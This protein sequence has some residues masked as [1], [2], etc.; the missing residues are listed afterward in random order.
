M[1]LQSR[2]IT[3]G[4]DK[5]VN[6]GGKNYVSGQVI[7]IKDEAGVLAPIF[8]DIDGLDPIAQNTISNVTNAKGQFTFFIEE[9][10]YTAE[11]N[12]QSIP[13]FVFG[14]DYFNNQIDFVTNQIL[15]NTQ[16]YSAGNFT[17]GFTFTELNQYGN[18]TVNDGG[19]DYATTFWYIG[20]TL[21]HTVAPLT[22]PRD[23]P[24]LYQ[25]R[26]FNS[27]E[28]IAT[29]TTENTQ[30]FIDSF[31]LK[32][33]QS[34]TDGLTKINTRTLLGGEVYEVRK[35]SDDSFATIYSD[36]DGDNEIVQNGISNVSGSDGV[37]IFYVADGS[38]YI[39]SGLFESNFGVGVNAESVS[40]FT[41]DLSKQ[42]ALV[43]TQETITINCPSDFANWQ[44]AID[45]A[46]GSLATFTNRIIVHLEAGYEI[47]NGLRLTGGD[48]SCIK[49]TSD[50]AIV[51]LSASFVGADTSGIPAGILGETPRQPL[52]CAYNANCPEWDVV[53]DMGNNY[54]T[55]HQLAEASIVVNP[56]KG[57]VNA[58]FRGIQVHGKANLYSA[59]YSGASGT[60]LR[61]QQASRVNA[62]DFNG[63]NS[64]KTD[65]LTNSAIYAS[66]SSILEFRGG[67]AINSGASGLIAR[68]SIVT[69][70]EA[71]FDGAVGFGVFSESQGANASFSNGSALNTGS[72]SVATGSAGEVACG[73]ADLSRPSSPANTLNINGGTIFVNAGTTVNGITGEAAIRGASNAPY[74][75]A[76]CFRGEIKY[77]DGAGAFDAGNYLT[78][79][80]YERKS[81]NIQ[82]TY[83]GA[84]TLNTGTVTPDSFSGN[85]TL[86][87]TESFTSIKSVKIEAVGRTSINGGGSRV[88]V[89]VFHDLVGSGN[90]FKIKN[91]SMQLD[92]SNTTLNVES[93]Q[94][95]IDIVGTWR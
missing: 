87:A 57:V 67:S 33:F 7:Y 31:A 36:K 40:K 18:A 3:A 95:Y 50:D 8:R 2:T 79:G 74:L 90:N 72:A 20:G 60:S 22:N 80:I 44:D 61:L 69:A 56:L 11:Y 48:Y 45:F 32:I 24:L 15:S 1:A 58:G 23:F 91:E 10:N 14:A 55:G 81:N 78:D 64:C 66:R 94:L 92:G 52:L 59:N 75:N 21:P 63:D 13:L 70:D 93:V 65:D 84:V 17:D 28:F 27:A 53:V 34:P 76:T 77:N 43:K 88:C 46:G 49:I 83:S 37:V 85:L 82:S 42:S 29:K 86:P 47:P 5:D 73:G 35:V 4:A 39:T 62:R 71:N 54:G 41:G 25:Q 12:D 30:D 51:N 19:T 9:G 16:P 89:S 38:Y 6:N 68:R 26:D